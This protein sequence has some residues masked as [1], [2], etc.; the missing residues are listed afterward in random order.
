M[1]R[2][3]VILSN[4]VHQQEVAAILLTVGFEVDLYPAPRSWPF[5]GEIRGGRCFRTNQCGADVLVV[6]DTLDS[7]WTGVQ[8]LLHQ[9]TQGC[10]CMQ[11]VHRDTRAAIVQ[12]DPAP[13]LDIG[14]RV[15]AAPKVGTPAWKA[16][17]TRW[18][19][20][21]IKIP[22]WVGEP[23]E[24]PSGDDVKQHLF[25]RCPKTDRVIPADSLKVVQE[26]FI[27]MGDIL[28]MKQVYR[29]REENW[30]LEDGTPCEPPQ[31]DLDAL[32]LTT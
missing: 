9:S 7:F 4:T 13:L 6:D 21:A 16:D 29:L 26:H 15:Y 20:N 17:F 5:L 2:A 3:V 25:M 31:G 14:V 32:R 23:V 10:K 27:A 30:C 1:A 22:S 18:A 8:V 28:A 19:Q 24:S 12:G 11:G